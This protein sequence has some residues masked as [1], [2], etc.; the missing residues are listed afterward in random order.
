[1][2]RTRTRTRPTPRRRVPVQRHVSLS[3]PSCAFAVAFLQRPR[4]FYLA[5][6]PRSM[7]HGGIL[8][9][10]VAIG[11]DDRLVRLSVVIEEGED[12]VED[13][14]QALDCVSGLGP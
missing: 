11:I 8:R 9:P 10:N 13:V 3:L 7:T 4:L 2:E 5:E 1:M 6:H 14:V 12:L